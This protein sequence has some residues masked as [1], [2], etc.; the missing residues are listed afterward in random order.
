MENF[1]VGG[2]K[3]LKLG[4]NGGMGLYHCAKP[5][6]PSWLGS[7]AMIFRLHALVFSTL[8]TEYHT[9]NMFLHVELMLGC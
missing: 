7:R 9:L 1:G 8:G 6:P 3:G 5:H 2:A 4:V